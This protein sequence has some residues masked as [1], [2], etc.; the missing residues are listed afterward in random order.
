MKV[1]WTYISV[2]HHKLDK[3]VF[4][5]LVAQ[6]LPLLWC[7]FN[8]WPGDFYMPWVQPGK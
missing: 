4:S 1:V 7:G 5:S 3:P 8:P 6:A 2:Y